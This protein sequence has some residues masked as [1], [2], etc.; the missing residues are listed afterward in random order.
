MES[1]AQRFLRYVKYNTQSSDRSDTYPSTQ[2]QLI[3]AK[4]LEDE[5]KAIGLA[6]VKVDQN[7]YVTATLP[8]NVNR[9]MPVIG[10]IAHMDTSPDMPGSGV[11]PRIV[12]NYDGSDIVLNAE[13]N[14][15]L[16]PREF[17]HLKNYIGQT[18]IVT[19]GTTLLG[20]DDKAGI[21]EIISAM[22]YL[23]EHP[24][25][26]HGT[27]RICFTPDE[28]IG[29]GVDR[30][31]VEEFGAHIA[32]TIDGGEIGELSYETFNAAGAR[33]T[34]HGRSIHT[35][36]AKGKMKNAIL[37]AMELNSMLPAD[38][39][40]ANTEGHQG[41]YHINEFSGNVDSA[42]MYYL[43]R[44]FDKDGFEKRKAKMQQIADKLNSKYGT[45]TVELDLYDQYYNMREII[46]QHMHVVETAKAAMRAAGIQPRIV[47]TRGGT[48]GAR[49]SYMGLPTPNLFTGGHNFHG[50]YEYIPIL[51]M[52]K[53]VE[54][55][56]N[57][58][59]AYGANA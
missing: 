14:I 45:G 39:I 13:Q 55:I 2:G 7:G 46:E 56:I 36:D 44:D 33:I 28:E 10:F 8:A 17:P 27:I 42:H 35:G 40:P 32:Y 43:I 20:A 11:N 31:N 50:R 15:L 23:I 29:H 16:S 9:N 18:L 57:I 5:L 48:D 37:I 24:D 54:V 49:L 51:A 25:I 34:I 3:F 47:P 30:F 19:D 38:E 59:K 21:A 1:V 52:E 6:Q 4:A 22:E 58:A 26:L 12:E 41:F 53:A